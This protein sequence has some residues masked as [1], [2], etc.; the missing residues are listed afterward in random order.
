MNDNYY[1]TDNGYN[2]CYTYTT[3]VNKNAYATVNW[4]VI[5][6]INNKNPNKSIEKENK[7]ITYTNLFD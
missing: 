4:N 3:T 6:K 7:K 5:S 1:T 2:S